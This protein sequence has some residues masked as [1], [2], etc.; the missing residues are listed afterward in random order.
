[1]RKIYFDAVQAMRPYDGEKIAYEQRILEGLIACDCDDE[2]EALFIVRES[3]NKIKNYQDLKVV[4][5]LVFNYMPGK[6][7][8]LDDYESTAFLI[9]AYANGSINQDEF[10]RKTG[11]NVRL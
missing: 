8:Y 10:Y 3:V 2:K 5:A 7:L 11:L 1:M 9:A 4:L 6:Y